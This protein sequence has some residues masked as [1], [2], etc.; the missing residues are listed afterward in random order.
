MPKYLSIH[1][2]ER[3]YKHLSRDLE[4]GDLDSDSKEG[5]LIVLN[6]E[7]SEL[8]VQLAEQQAARQ[9]FSEKRAEY[10]DRRQRQKTHLER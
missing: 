10:Q 1:A 5:E 8:Q 2:Y 3:F 6:T 7:I 9:E 4:T